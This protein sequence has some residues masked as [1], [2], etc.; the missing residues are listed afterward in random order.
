MKI[1]NAENHVEMVKKLMPVIS[2][3]YN[4]YQNLHLIKQWNVHRLKDAQNPTI[5][6]LRLRGSTRTASSRGHKS[7]RSAGDV[8]W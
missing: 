2:G 4:L 7:L 5:S 6:S 3:F 8:V 1:C